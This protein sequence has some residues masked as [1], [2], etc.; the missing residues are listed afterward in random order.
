MESYGETPCEEDTTFTVILYEESSSSPGASQVS[1]KSTT[2][3]DL[4]GLGDYIPPSRGC[5]PE[6][7]L[8]N[9]KKSHVLGADSWWCLCKAWKRRPKSAPA[10]VDERRR[11]SASTQARYFSF[12]AAAAVENAD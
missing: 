3:S 6:G 8:I 12:P 5:H 2:D 4:P 10:V 9:S 7:E 11:E 1:T